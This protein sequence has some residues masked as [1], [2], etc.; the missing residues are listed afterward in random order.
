MSPHGLDC[1]ASMRRQT[2]KSMP[3][4]AQPTV[5]TRRSIP[6][7]MAGLELQGGRSTRSTPTPDAGRV[8]VWRFTTQAPGIAG[9][10]PCRWRCLCALEALRPVSGPIRL[11]PRPTHSAPLA[12]HRLHTH[13]VGVLD[14][15][16]AV[17]NRASVPTS[18]RSGCRPA[19]RNSRSQ[20]SDTIRPKAGVGNLHP[21]QPLLPQ[22][23]LADDVVLGSPA[24]NRAASGSVA[25]T[26]HAKRQM[27]PSVPLA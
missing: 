22:P 9:A 7:Q 19:H 1:S 26:P 10:S 2:V 6:V 23:G 15:P 24:A 5:I 3:R 14:K 8:G 13:E 4:A 20:S 27:D 25:G 16:K 18:A 11:P 12:P 17:R 21:N